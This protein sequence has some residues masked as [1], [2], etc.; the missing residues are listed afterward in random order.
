[1]KHIKKFNESK[2]TVKSQPNS[3][4]LRKTT[5]EDWLDMYNFLKTNTTFLGK[6][7]NVGTHLDWHESLSRIPSMFDDN[8]IVGIN[9]S[10]YIPSKYF[11]QET[12]DFQL[13]KYPDRFGKSPRCKVLCSIVEKKDVS[14]GNHDVPDT[15]AKNLEQFKEY[16]LMLMK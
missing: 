16:C 10:S 2:D 9:V 4:W 15:E 12:I 14:G 11:T 13:K 5:K 3:F 6:N 1:M 7:I 8:N